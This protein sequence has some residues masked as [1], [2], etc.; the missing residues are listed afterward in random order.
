MEIKVELY[1]DVLRVRFGDTTHL[2]VEV[3]KLLGFQSWPERYGNKKFIIQY[4]LK[5]G[6]I[7]CEYDDEAKWKTIL[8]G[9][10]KALNQPVA[11]PR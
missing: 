9:L 7:I 5:G 3:T 2:H 1:F 4:V 11:M 6:Q 8:D 10:D